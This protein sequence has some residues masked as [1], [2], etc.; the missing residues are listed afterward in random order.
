MART[1]EGMNKSWMPAC[2][3]MTGLGRAGVNLAP[4]RERIGSVLGCFGRYAASQ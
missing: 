2:A 3:G 4:V 1:V